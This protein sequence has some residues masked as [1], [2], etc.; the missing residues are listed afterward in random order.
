MFIVFS[1]IN[2]TV[3]SQESTHSVP[4]YRVVNWNMDQGFPHKKINSIYKDA[5]GFLWIGTVTGLS[6]FDGSTFKNYFHGRGAAEDV[7]AGIIQGIR[8]DNQHNIWIGSGEGLWRY[9]NIADTFKLFKASDTSGDADLFIIPF[10]VKNEELFCIEADSII[11]AYNTKSFKKKVIS[12]LPQK[13][14]YNAA[15]QFSV[16]DTITNAVWML[17]GSDGLCAVSIGTGIMQCYGYGGEAMCYDQRR[18]AIWINSGS[19]LTRVDIISRQFQH[20]SDVDNYFERGVGIDVDGDGNVWVGTG[21]KGVFLYNPDS[22]FVYAPFSKDSSLNTLVNWA[23]YRMYCDR[24]GMVWIGYYTQ[25]GKGITQLIPFYPSVKRYNISPGAFTVEG[26]QWQKTHDGNLWVCGDHEMNVFNP[27][28]GAVHTISDRQLSGI[29]ISKQVSFIGVDSLGNS[30]WLYKQAS[31]IYQLDLATLH[32]RLIPAEDLSGNTLQHIFPD[33]FQIK[34]F[35]NGLIFLE[36][37]PGTGDH[38]V[39]AV[40]GNARSCK[41]LFDFGHRKITNI[42]T[43][44]GQMI[45]LRLEGERLNRSFKLVNN[46]WR[47]VATPLDSISWIDVQYNKD[48]ET[49][50]AGGLMEIDHFDQDFRLIG[51]YTS[52][53]GIHDIYVYSVTPDNFGNLWFNGSSGYVSRLN[54]ATGVITTLSEKDGY[55]KQPFYNL[56]SGLK[57][58]IGNIYFRGYGIIERIDPRKYL[59]VTSRAYLKAITIKSFLLPTEIGVN[60]ISGLSLKYFQ[61]SISVETGTIDYYSQGKNHIRYK[62]ESDNTAQD[63]VYANANYTIQYE[64][65][66]PGNYKLIIQAG[67][68]GNEFNGPEKILSFSISPAFWNTWWFRI[69]AA[70]FIVAVAYFVTRYFTRQKYRLQL[71]RSEKERQIATIRQKAS[72]LEMQALRAQ[73][74]PHFIF[75]SLNSINRF[76]L[77]KQSLE[78][79]GYLTKFS[80]LIRMILNSSTQNTL[81]LE[82]DLEAL[83]LYLELERLRCDDRFNFIIKCSKEID[84]ETIQVPPMLMQPFV[85]NAIW[86]GLMHKESEGNLVVSVDQYDALLVCTITD[87]GVGRKKSAEMKNKSG[88]HQSMGMKITAARIAMLNK[89]GENGS[90]VNIKDLMNEDGTAAGT[91]VTITIPVQYD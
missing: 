72:E 68:L 85:E 84:A 12:H 11:T 1:W 6:R 33:D 35:K 64:E 37:V 45:F 20:V 65:L 50:W 10:W 40:S 59:P 79:S 57:D 32:N 78:A 73:M 5:N 19:G 80:K 29:D 82:E 90:P 47:Q 26:G 46:N 66:P 14:T 4:D 54:I 88:K 75:N 22:H 34:P 83:K 81:S 2:V 76:I 39:F 9:D 49:W 51:R 7:P 52:E 24:E 38:A 61:N 42:A 70:A 31:E 30:A 27:S 3:F 62:L 16:Y 28:T 18:K 8:E 44:G 21:N 77:K 87:D 48:D 43:D 86:H 63:W 13:I 69:L 67:N 53:Q 58:D 71:E 17:A 60:N 36:G 55:A 25:A 91:E 23:N 89:M 74:N 15:L 41:Q 56:P